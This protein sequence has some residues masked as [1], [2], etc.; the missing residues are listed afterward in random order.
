MHIP[1][2]RHLRRGGHLTPGTGVPA[3]RRRLHQAPDGRAL[4][5]CLVSAFLIH[6]EA[7]PPLQGV[8]LRAA[9]S[10]VGIHGR[11]TD[12]R[13]VRTTT[14]LL[15]SQLSQGIACGVTYRQATQTG[16]TAKLHQEEILLRIRVGYMDRRYRLVA[17]VL[18][19]TLP[20]P[21]PAR[22]SHWCI[23][24]CAGDSRTCS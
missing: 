23:P 18:E 6:G 2:G 17:S 5:F 4:L 11:P 7:V 21:S 19:T 20:A 16:S 12:P 9:N 3:L 13:R 1:G 10:P 24:H 14:T 8:S 15:I 22:A